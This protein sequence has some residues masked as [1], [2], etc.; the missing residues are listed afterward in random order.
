MVRPHR[1]LILLLLALLDMMVHP[2]LLTMMA[3]KYMGVMMILVT[4][5][6]AVLAEESCDR[7]SK[8]HQEHWLLN[9]FIFSMIH[10]L[11][12]VLLEGEQESDSIISFKTCEMGISLQ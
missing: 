2:R 8:I 1:L 4:E 9:R 3:M 5:Y 7:P 12:V 11:G 6:F 10:L